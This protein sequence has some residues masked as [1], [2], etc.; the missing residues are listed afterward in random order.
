M[1]LLA[2]LVAVANSVTQSLG[3]QASVLH[4]AFVSAD[5]AGKVSYAAAVERT[6]IVTEKQ[7]LVRT[8]SGEMAVSNASVVFLDPSAVGEFDKIVLPVNGVLDIST[9]ARDNAQPLIAT[10]A[11]ID[12]TNAAILTEIYIGRS[13]DQP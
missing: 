12:D 9:T 7:K 2:G 13:A 11:F 8:F 4:Y 6:A 10:D 5:G 1:S 3:L